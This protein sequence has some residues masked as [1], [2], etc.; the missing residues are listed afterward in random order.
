MKGEQKVEHRYVYP[1]N[2]TKYVYFEADGKT[3]KRQ[4]Q[5]PAG[6]FDIKIIP[7]KYDALYL[8]NGRR[9]NAPRM[10]IEVKDAEFVIFTDKDGKDLTYME[11]GKEYLAC[12][13]WYHLG[14][15]L[16]TENVPTEQ[17]S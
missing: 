13:V 17:G 14:N 12:Q 4:E 3:Y 1:S 9:K 16:K 15:V 2:V 11:G 10:L 5:I 6:D 8:I 7:V